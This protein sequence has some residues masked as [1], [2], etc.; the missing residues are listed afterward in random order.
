MMMMMK[1]DYLIKYGMAL[2]DVWFK[3][4]ALIY[5]IWM[6]NYPPTMNGNWAS[7][8]NLFPLMQMLVT[9]V[10]IQ[11]IERVSYF[12]CFVKT[13]FSLILQIWLFFYQ[14]CALAFIRVWEQMLLNHCCNLEEFVENID[15][16]RFLFLFYI[17]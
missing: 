16:L 17:K 8:T 10:Y 12:S 13:L 1:N 6:E 4:W 5:R 15:P 7:T 3:C 11:Y 2:V 14:K 9:V